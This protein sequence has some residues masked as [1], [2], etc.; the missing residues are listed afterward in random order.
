MFQLR[1]AGIPDNIR[2]DLEMLGAH[3]LTD[4]TWSS[5]NTAKRMLAVCCKQNNLKKELPVPESTIL[6]FIHWLATVRNL[7]SGTIN[8]YL[9]GIRQFHIANGMP[10]PSIRSDTIN[11]ILKGVQNK[12]ARDRLANKNLVKQPITEA[13][14]M[15]LKTSLRSWQA[16]T[17]DHR[18]IWAVATNLY[19]GL[20]RVR[21]L[22]AEKEQEFDPAF[23]LLTDDIRVSKVGQFGSAH[24]QLKAPK[25]D[26]KKRSKIVD[27]YG[28]GNASCPVQAL[29]KWQ[30]RMDWPANQPAFRWSNGVPLTAKKFN[31]VLRGRLGEPADGSRAFSSHCFRIGVASRL[32]HLG[33]SD[34]EVKAMGRWSSRAFEEYLLHPRTKRATIAKQAKEF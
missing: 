17:T 16:D 24:F 20:F 2:K 30:A 9:A 21:E 1:Q 19:H 22:L 5:Y 15:T 31:Q 7:K 29:R 26:K 14:M 6:I 8:N 33:Y 13:T 11:L 32:G 23:T 4:K 34:E 12:E 18:L 27:V 3:S 28:T 10:D 25:E